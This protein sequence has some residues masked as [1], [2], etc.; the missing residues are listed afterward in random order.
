MIKD[1][2]KDG[3][4]PK[5]WVEVDGN[6]NSKKFHALVDTGFDFDIALHY[7]TNW[8]P[9]STLSSTSIAASI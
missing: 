7:S 6:S 1:K 9:N 5:I 3:L 4:Y 2:I 8:I